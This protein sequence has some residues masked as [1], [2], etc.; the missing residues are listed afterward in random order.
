M[1]VRHCRV[2]EKHGYQWGDEGKCYTFPYGDMQA[3]KEAYNQAL[4]QGRAIE[5]EKG[6]EDE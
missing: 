6:K 2:G 1:P 3:E 5:S 4:A